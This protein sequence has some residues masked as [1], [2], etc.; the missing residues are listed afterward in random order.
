MSE[1]QA[2]QT[3][4]NEWG[5]KARCPACSA[6]DLEVRHQPGGPDQL[7]CTACG[8]R[9]ELELDGPH[10][11]VTRWPDLRVPASVPPP[12][13][14]LSIDELRSLLRK[15]IASVD[16]AAPAPARPTA[17]P[18]SQPVAPATAAIRPATPPPGPEA[19]A[20]AQPSASPL[21]APGVAVPKGLVVRVKKLLDTGSTPM[22]LRAALG[23]DGLSPAEIQAAIESADQ[24]RR[25]DHEGQA[26]K[27]WG[28]LAL[29]AILLSLAVW[30]GFRLASSLASRQDE[31]MNVLRSTL[32]PNLAHSVG[33]TTPVVHRLPDPPGASRGTPVPCPQTPQDA[34][35]LFGGPAETWSKGP[36]GW[37]RMDTSGVD[38]TIHVPYGML[39]MYFKVSNQLVAVEVPGPATLNQIPSMAISC[40]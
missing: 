2:R 9:F 18:A 21:P 19:A 1:I 30:G 22:E 5:E 35:D 24:I 37:V 20:P 26:R 33:M 32:A 38:V 27:L 4:P 39:A 10:L 34:A 23:K 14:W 8:L 17:G 12:G 28:R 29:A 7:R 31:F 25:R 11:S 40:P 13:S 3:I 36:N 6:P 16:Q 15:P